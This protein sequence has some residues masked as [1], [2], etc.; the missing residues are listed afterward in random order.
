MVT[1]T[2]DVNDGRCGARCSL[3]DAIL[4]AN[5]HP[6]ADLVRVPAGTYTLRIPGINEDA[7]ATG[8]LDITGPVALGGAGEG[9]TILDGARI[10]RVLSVLGDGPTSISG[11][12]IRHGLAP[13]H[14][15][16]GGG[17]LAEGAAVTLSHVTVTDNATVPGITGDS[18][19]GGIETGFIFGELDLTLNNVTITGNRA[20]YRGGISLDTGGAR[21]SHV[22]ISDNTAD[23]YGGG[24]YGS[25][26]PATITDSVIRNNRAGGDGGALLNIGDVR[27]G[28]DAQLRLTRVEVDRNSTKGRGG[29]LANFDGGA[30]SIIDSA[31]VGNRAVLGAFAFNADRLDV[32]NSTL[33]GNT[34]STGGV[35]LN[36]GA[37][38]ED[39][40][41][42]PG[43]GSLRN[44][45]FAGNRA[46]IENLSL[47]GTE[48]V[49]NSILSNRSPNCAR[50]ADAGSITSTGGNL[51][52]GRTCAFAA[53]GDRSGVDPRLAGLADNGGPTLTMALHTGSPARDHALDSACPS[54]DQRGAHRPR[55]PHCDIGALG[56]APAA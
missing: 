46:G 51:D 19:G 5:A 45:T 4:A 40:F 43:T 13:I 48:T 37:D 44:V 24:V 55:G 29:A 3:R 53:T 39:M 47:S 7:G 10:D 32:T 56:A 14:S 31:F 12:T 28:I 30:V 35:L 25:N 26:S 2:A 8:D 27:D 1:T 21:M 16:G 49:V 34:S 17:I 9:R 33:S 38:P 36:S 41:S 23:G 42:T 15:G 54:N 50:T 20:H 6:G 11:L 22:E 18:S 52:S